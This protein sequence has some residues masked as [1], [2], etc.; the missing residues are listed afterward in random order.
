[1]DPTSFD[2]MASWGLYGITFECIKLSAML[3]WST[4]LPLSM[5]LKL[6]NFLRYNMETYAWNIWSVNQNTQQKK[7]SNTNKYNWS[8]KYYP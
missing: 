5:I 6:E 1:M 7:E 3:Y 2:A 8:L 4:S